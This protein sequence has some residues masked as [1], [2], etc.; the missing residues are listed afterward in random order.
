[1][2]TITDKKKITQKHIEKTEKIR[3][4]GTNL[5]EVKEAYCIVSFD[6][7]VRRKGGADE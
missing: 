2:N 1:M 6:T 4:I 7:I 3:R 5:K